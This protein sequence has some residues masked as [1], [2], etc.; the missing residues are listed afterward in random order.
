MTELPV[1][2]YW[3]VVGDDN[4]LIGVFPYD[5]R[6]EMEAD[7]LARSRHALVRICVIQGYIVVTPPL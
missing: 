3:A 6:G 4:G 2:F 5:P 7:A 1:T